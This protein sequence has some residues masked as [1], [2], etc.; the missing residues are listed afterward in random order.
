M[1]MKIYIS[2]PISGH[3]LTERMAAFG[4][5]ADEVERRGFEAVNPLENGLPPEASHERHMKADI[6]NLLECD[7]IVRTY[8]PYRSEGC[9]M[10]ANV[11]KAC[12]IPTAG[13]ITDTLVIDWLRRG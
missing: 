6:K 2:M 5:I 13:F 8:N 3:D 12:G 9:L 10:E 4:K 11:A 7:F 1:A